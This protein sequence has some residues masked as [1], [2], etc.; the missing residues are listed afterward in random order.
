MTLPI[1]SKPQCVPVLPNKDTASQEP[2]TSKP[3]P[4]RVNEIIKDDPISPLHPITLK[5]IHQ[6]IGEREEAFFMLDRARLRRQ[7][8]LWYSHLP[9]VTPYYAVKCN[10]EPLILDELSRYGNGPGGVG[11]DCAS[12]AEFNAVLETNRVDPS[13]IVYAHTIK[14]PHHIQRAREVGVSRMTVDSVEEMGKIARNYPGARVILRIW[15][16]DQDSRIPLGSKF[17]ADEGEWKE[18]METAIRYNL[19]FEGI[20]FHV[21]SGCVSG[22]P[23]ERAITMARRAFELAWNLGLSPK[24][25]DIGGG[26]PGEG[27]FGMG[28]GE[29]LAQFSE[30]TRVI[31]PSLAHHFPETLGVRV[32]AEP[33]QFLVSGACTLITRVLGRRLR[34][35]SDGPTMHYYLDDGACG[36]FPTVMEDELPCP[37]LHLKE[38]SEGEG[39]EE[40]EGGQRRR[41]YASTLW[42][43]TCTVEDLILERTPLP[44]M[45]AGEWMVWRSMGAYTNARATTFNGIPIP[46]Y[47]SVDYHEGEDLGSVED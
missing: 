5:R 25:L 27:L 41:I 28:R 6:V 30:I 38:A 22:K 26:F 37:P 33:G 23:F 20:S 8:N 47:F 42:G 15:V 34:Y 35:E 18:L 7:V 9:S 11:F 2:H 32:I 46:P 43:P 21:G 10:P 4:P 1:N 12:A 36:S 31:R 24:L 29:K 45:R 16:N 19:S 13:Q 39:E 14:V 40:K 44:E 3:F 17:G